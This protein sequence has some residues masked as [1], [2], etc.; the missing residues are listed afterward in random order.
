L[1]HRK[2]HSLAVAF[3]ACSAVV[4]LAAAGCGG[5]SSGGTGGSVN[6]NVDT[7]LQ[8]QS[9][10]GKKFDLAK[11]SPTIK[12][13]SSPVT[14]TF[15]GF[16]LGPAW[17]KLAKQ[18][19]QIH[20]NI[21]VNIVNVP[22]ENQQTKLTTQIAGGNAPDAAYVDAGSVGA[23]APR[24]ALVN[25]DDYMSKSVSTPK[26][27]FVPAFIKMTSY[28]GSVYGLPIDGESTGLFYRTDLFQQAGITSPPKTWDELNADAAKLTNPAKKQY[29]IAMFATQGETSYYWYNFLYQAGGTQTTSDDKHA[30]FASDD[31]IRAGQEYTMLAQKYSPPDLWAS[32][33]WDGRVT[34]ATGKVG[35]YI[36]GA[37]F[38]GEMNNSFPKIKGKW[39]AAPLP[40]ET[41]GSQCANTIAGDALVILAQSKNPDAAWKWIEFVDAPQNMALLNLGT[42]KEPASLLP[43]RNSLIGDPKAFSAFPLLHDF[44]LG[45]KC[46]ITNLSENPHWGE[47]D[48]GP[49]SDAL[50]KGIYGKQSIDQA[51]KSAAQQGDQILQQP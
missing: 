43:P 32:N 51:L 2:P 6:T 15:Q 34:F 7:K 13:P 25:L 50:A 18:F 41:E 1:A 40:T 17:N 31:G 29:G 48:S 44:A 38:A 9:L 21:T 20:P 5:G 22:A 42:K 10:I 3:A 37:W 8:S 4:A 46:G 11:L 26:G 35:M 30:A 24:G 16:N 45:L 33:S 12:D 49:L 14:I 27:D 36:A 19:H 47:V 28:N 23:F 39:A